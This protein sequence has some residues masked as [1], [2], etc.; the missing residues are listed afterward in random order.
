M[1]SPPPSAGPYTPFSTLAGSSQPI[2][3]PSRAKQSRS[4][5]AARE[6]SATLV[7]IRPAGQAGPAG[8]RPASLGHLDALRN[9]LI[10][11]ASEL[12]NAR[13]VTSALSHEGHEGQTDLARLKL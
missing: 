13:P 7:A 6:S 10:N 9:Q 2:A 11:S 4:W 3:S 5:G 8:F 1:V 12:A